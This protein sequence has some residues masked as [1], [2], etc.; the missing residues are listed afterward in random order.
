MNAKLLVLGT[1]AGALTLFAWETISNAVIPWHAAT[2]RTFTDSN[3]VVQA[4]KANAPENGMYVEMR[5]I[6][7]AVSFTPDMKDKSTLLPLMLG[8][9]FVLDLAV[10]LVL[11]LAM[12]RLP[13]ASNM[14][15]AFGTAAIALA[16]SASIFVS[17]WNWYGFGTAWTVVNTIDRMIGYGLMGLALGASVNRWPG[18]MRT[19]EWG[20]VKAPGGVPSSMG[21][22]TPGSHG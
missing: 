6:V 17:D 14:Q 20:G 9:Q 10:A 19:D 15:Y 13:R 2:M 12:Q 18:R 22:P 1:L 8:R 4:I 21:S 11:L 5:G 7:A 16:V 3:A